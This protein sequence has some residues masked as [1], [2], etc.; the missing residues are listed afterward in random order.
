MSDEPVIDLRELARVL[1]ETIDLSV[2]LEDEG[3]SLRI[4]LFESLAKPRHYCATIWRLE[5]YRIQS[6]FPQVAGGKPAHQPSDEQ[7]LRVF[8]G[9][10][11]PLDEPLEFPDALAARDYVLE[12]FAKW[13]TVQLGVPAQ[14]RRSPG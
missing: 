14:W 3:L 8:E 6:T 1:V 9:Y 13:L 4:E 2:P 10:E 11:S 5:F 7:I 12:Q